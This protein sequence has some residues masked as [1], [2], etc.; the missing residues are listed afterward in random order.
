MR[1]LAFA[2]SVSAAVLVTVSGAGAGH[3]TPGGRQLKVALVTDLIAA[4]NPHDLRG[5]AYLGFLRAVKDFGV[6]GRA[7]QYNPRQGQRATLESLGRQKYDLILP[8]I[9][10]SNEDFQAIGAVAARFPRSKFATFVGSVQ[11][12]TARPKNLRGSI[13][14]SEQPGYLAGYL[15]GLMEKRRPGKDVIGSVGGFSIPEV[16]SFIAGYEAGAKQADPR[17]TTLR[18]YA[19]FLDAAKCKA[20][21][22]RQIAKGA[23]VVFNVAGICGLGTLRAAK[24]ERVWGIGVDVDQSFL[25]RHILTSAVEHGDIEVYN[26]VKAFVRGR[27]K[28]PGNSVWSLRNGALG[29]G[30]ISPKVP[31]PFVRQVGR[32]RKQIIAGKIKVPSKVS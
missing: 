11:D 27:L 28:T 24:A 14:H 1:Y 12:F 5:I 7:F 29:L 10:Q 25:G 31:R 2:L 4:P 30:K 8:G 22:R 20:A 16:D 17:I 19:G 15:A 18:S 23:G 6:Q 3:A 13:R 26:T 32:I 9:P 21:A